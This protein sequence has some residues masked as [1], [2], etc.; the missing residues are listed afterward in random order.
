LVHLDLQPQ[1]LLFA[2]KTTTPTTPTTTT[3]TTNGGS[4]TIESIGVSSVLDWEDAAIADPQFEV[5]LLGRKVC[6]NCEQAKELWQLYSEMYN[7]SA[8]AS[9]SSSS[10]NTTTD[11]EQLVVVVVVDDDVGPLG[12][13]FQLETIHSIVTL[14]LQSMD[15]L[16]G[17]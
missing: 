15:L 11:E 17:G 4:S 2:A 5:L 16:D 7:S 9:S 10:S 14:L 13:W 12:P 6:A 8:D 3:T 1:N